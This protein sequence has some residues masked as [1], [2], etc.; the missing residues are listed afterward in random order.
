MIELISLSVR[1][2]LYHLHEVTASIETGEYFVVT[3]PAGGGKTVLLE[4]LIGLHRH[5]R[6]R[7]LL[8]G[9]NMR[10]V[11]VEARS[12]AY[13]PQDYGIFPHLSVQ[14]NLV[15]GARERG[16]GRDD[17]AKE[18]DEL[19]DLF[20]LRTVLTRTKAVG[21][22]TSEQQRIAIARALLSR[23]AV[24]VLDEPMAFLDAPVRREMMLRLKRL[25][26]TSGVTIIHATRDLDEALALGTRVA[27][28]I[29][30]RVQQVTRPDARRIRPADATVARWIAGRNVLPATVRSADD[31]AGTAL[32]TCGEAELTAAYGGGKLS[33]GMAVLVGFRA[34]EAW[35]LGTEEPP[36]GANMLEGTVGALL[37]YGST[38]TLV[39]KVATLG[40][41][42]EVAVPRLASAQHRLADGARVRIAVPPGALWL[43]ER[44]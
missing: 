39:A 10:G 34:Q 28:L 29:E 40:Q 41:E 18:L 35:L 23:P 44:D 7:I 33:S 13:V 36:E 30:G 22:S 43:V 21:L 14:A 37:S 16:L 27:V 9:T 32:V 6:G 8:D 3:G 19:L 31:A 42:V 2:G 20:D 15:Y 12:I 25:K 5:Y 26:E 11:P 1:F 4:T 24:L 38:D 17:V